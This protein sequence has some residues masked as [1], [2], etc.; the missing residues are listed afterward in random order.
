MA[1]LESLYILARAKVFERYP[2]TLLI[3]IQKANA[4]MKDAEYIRFCVLVSYS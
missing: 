2:N 1:Q 4:N 3:Y